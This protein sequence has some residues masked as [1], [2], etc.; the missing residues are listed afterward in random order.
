[1]QRVLPGFRL[2]F[3]LRNF[4]KMAIALTR[5]E[6][7]KDEYVRL[8]DQHLTDLV[9]HNATEMHEIEDFAGLLFIHPIHLSNTIKDFTGVSACEI[10]QTKIMDVAKGLLHNSK[11][12]IRQIALTLTFEPSQFTKWFKKYAGVTPKQ[13]R[14]N[15]PE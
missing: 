3:I 1:L 10:Y 13:F 6:Q 14:G 8:I 15:K 7:L 11:L 12:T 5:P 2:R 4:V 9:E